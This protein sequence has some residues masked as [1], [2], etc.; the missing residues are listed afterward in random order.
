M[1]HG[2]EPGNATLFPSALKFGRR[3]LLTYA[4]TGIVVALGIGLQMVH[5]IGKKP[6]LSFGTIS[7][8]ESIR[9]SEPIVA[10]QRS[11]GGSAILLATNT[12]ELVL[13][14]AASA[15]P[16]WRSKA[17]SPPLDRNSILFGNDA[18]YVVD[19]TRVIALSIVDGKVLW[20]VPLIADVTYG[21][22]DALMLSKSA[23]LVLERD[24]SLQ[25]F[26]RRTGTQ[27]WSKKLDY[28]PNIFP[29]GKNNII[30]LRP[31]GM[32]K[33]KR[34][35]V[36][37]VDADSGKPSVPCQSITLIS[38]STNSPPPTKTQDSFSA[39][40]AATS[41]WSM[42]SGTNALSD[43]AWKIAQKSGKTAGREQGRRRAFFSP[44]WRCSSLTVVRCGP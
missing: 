41:M 7:Q 22:K 35:A 27:V 4:V 1:L 19:Q 11:S 30:I 36:D 26:D 38:Y 5:S 31:V 21:G 34:N 16:L 40:T 17:F 39:K 37:I 32:E 44:T 33:E 43:G 10:L 15:K 24:G 42:A 3:Y 13:I 25:A 12:N 28:R 20:Q 2:A 6:R 8:A 14:N 23:V 18:I 9:Y 29:R